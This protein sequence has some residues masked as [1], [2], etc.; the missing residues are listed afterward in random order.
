MTSHP[1]PGRPRVLE[2]HTPTPSGPPSK[3][4][5][6]TH[7]SPSSVAEPTSPDSQGTDSFPR[8]YSLPRYRSTLASYVTRSRTT[9]EPLSVTT[10]P[11]SVGNG[12]PDVSFGIGRWTTEGTRPSPRLRSPV[13]DTPKRAHLRSGRFSWTRTT[14]TTCGSL[15]HE[16]TVAEGDRERGSVSKDRSLFVADVVVGKGVEGHEAR[17]RITGRQSVTPRKA[18]RKGRLPTHW[19]TRNRIKPTSGR[20]GHPKVE[21]MHPPNSICQ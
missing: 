20:S 6:S 9:D 15:E 1:C 17:F 4:P 7:R 21:G 18:G 10:L 13:T 11:Q 19:E 12:D 5:R 3:R 2:P 8:Q 14:Y 16:R